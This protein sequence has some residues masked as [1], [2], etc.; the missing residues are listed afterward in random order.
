MTCLG[1]C[2]GENDKSSYA[3]DVTVNTETVNT[4]K[5]GQP[6]NTAQIK[7]LVIF[8]A[9]SPSCCHRPWGMSLSLCMHFTNNFAVT[10]VLW[11]SLWIDGILAFLPFL[12]CL[13]PP[14]GLLGNFPPSV[15]KDLQ[16]W[17]QLS[18]ILTEEGRVVLRNKQQICRE[19][20]RGQLEMST[21]P[22]RK[23]SSQ[24]LKY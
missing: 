3:G 1:S 7:T 12:C 20:R 18:L 11:L 8:C 23:L 2:S 24:L 4:A 16:Q 9:R 6:V 17:E 21:T 13:L 15:T 10:D 19:V 14:T 22:N 5:A